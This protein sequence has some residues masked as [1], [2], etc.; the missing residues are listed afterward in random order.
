MVIDGK[1]RAYSRMSVGSD[2]A[3]DAE[4]PLSGLIGR[5]GFAR[6]ARRLLGMHM[7]NASALT[8]IEIDHFDYVGSRF[9]QDCANMVLR[10]VAQQLLQVVRGQDVVGR[11]D[12]T[13]FAVLHCDIDLA[14]V[15][16]VGERLR[17]SVQSI[18]FYAED[19]TQIPVTVSIGIE[20]IERTERLRGPDLKA[21]I[22]RA[23]ERVGEAK[24]A[25]CNRVVAPAQNAA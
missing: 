12:E 6:R 7:R 14:A 3:D 21:C 15:R 10:G 22:A 9:G 20:V 24:A 19:G 18:G 23:G 8:L 11:I 4:D 2:V 5:D 13:T 17:K 16:A 1:K 25:G